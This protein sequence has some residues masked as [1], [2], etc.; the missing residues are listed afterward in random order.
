MDPVTCPQTG[1]VM[2]RG[3]RPMTLEFRGETVTFEMPGWYLD[4]VEDGIHS[5]A[6]MEISDRYLNQ[7]KTLKK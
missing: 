6:D 2:T 5:D 7:L 3:I 4:G 1:K